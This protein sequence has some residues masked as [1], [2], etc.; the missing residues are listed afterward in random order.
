MFCV[1]ILDS[2]IC[3]GS[4]QDDGKKEKI[5]FSVVDHRL[6]I[7]GIH[8]WVCDSSARNL[9]NTE[10]SAVADYLSVQVLKGCTFK[11]VSFSLLLSSCHH[12]K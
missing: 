2:S 5:F 11:F 3:S 6:F 10:R 1:S 4:F 8:C 9:S 7:S 12:R